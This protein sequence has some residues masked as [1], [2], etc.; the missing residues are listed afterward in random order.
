MSLLHHHYG[1][2][3]RII[4]FLPLLILAGCTKSPDTT[5]ITPVTSTTSIQSTTTV[6]STTATP[7][8]ETV[9]IGI[10]ASNK[11][12]VID[13]YKKLIANIKVTDIGWTGNFSTC[14]P[15]VISQNFIKSQ[16]NKYLFTRQ[17]AGIGE[18]IQVPDSL[19]R[20][21]MRIATAFASYTESGIFGEWEK[22]PCY[23][24]NM[25]FPAN[26]QI[27][28]CGFDEQTSPY[29]DPFALLMQ[30]FDSTV[31]TRRLFLDPQIT[32]I[33]FGEV[34]GR[35]GS[36]T[37]S[38]IQ[39]VKGTTLPKT[40]DT[41]I[42]I[43]VNG[44]NINLYRYWSFA[45]PNADFTKATITIQKSGRTLKSPITFRSK[46]GADPLGYLVWDMLA[47]DTSELSPYT[48]KI[49]DVF[50]NGKSQSFTYQV[51]YIPYEELR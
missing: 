41:Y 18:S 28:S 31:A 33:G 19:N 32:S 1:N 25:E 23:D 47:Q 6:S 34:I 2:M 11:Q 5:P 30:S 4:P 45:Y 43:P 9:L 37:Y 12:A 3:I 35:K 26:T 13:A 17:L 27:F 49:D 21:M 50:V 7:S 40:R 46:S 39:A 16:I 42:A 15:G 10:D 14:Q 20:K 51:K 24:K 48:V 22:L 36:R 38:S 29:T 8:N 44:Y